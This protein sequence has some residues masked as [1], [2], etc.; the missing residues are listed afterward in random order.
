[1]TPAEQRRLTELIDPEHRNTDIWNRFDECLEDE[2]QPLDANFV[3][4]CI[5]WAKGQEWFFRDHYD[6]GI[7]LKI[8]EYLRFN[9]PLNPSLSAICTLILEAAERNGK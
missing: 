9:L 4:A 6:G 8:Q 2:P 7:A 1:M 3:F 5:E